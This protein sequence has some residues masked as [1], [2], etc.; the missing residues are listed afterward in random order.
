MSKFNGKSLVA[1]FIRV[2]FTEGYGKPEFKEN[3]LFIINIGKRNSFK[4]VLGFSNSKSATYIRGL[5]INF[6]HRSI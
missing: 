3:Y 2:L 5:A 4:L 6:R 1:T